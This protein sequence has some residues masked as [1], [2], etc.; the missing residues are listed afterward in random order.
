MEAALPIPC[1]GPERHSVLSSLALPCV[2]HP[3]RERC[4][5]C[6]PEKKTV[7]LHWRPVLRP[8]ITVCLRPR[9]KISAA[10]GMHSFCSPQRA[11][12][13][14]H[15]HRMLYEN[16]SSV[17]HVLSRA[18]SD[19]TLGPP[20]FENAGNRRGTVCTLCC[21]LR[22]SSRLLPACRSVKLAV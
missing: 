15:P 4:R 18:A 10:G 1:L 3:P 19:E 14:A 13:K 20:S 8:Q 2:S 12:Q 22:S 6:W 5:Y 17:A 7:T 16:T 9:C 11:P 21:F